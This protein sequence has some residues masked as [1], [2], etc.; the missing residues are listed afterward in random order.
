MELNVILPCA[1]A[2]KRLGLSYPKELYEI[3]P[4]IRLIDFS[5]NH[6]LAF[7][8]KN[9]SFKN[10]IELKIS[11]VIRPGKEEIIDY[12]RYRCP[13][14][15]IV[16]VLFNNDYFEWPGSVYSAQAVFEKKNLVLL[17]DSLLLVDN[18]C[19]YCNQQGKTLLEMVLS[20]LEQNNVCFGYI[21]CS[22]PIIL[23]Q[24]GA[25]RISH[26]KVELFCDKPHRMTSL[27]NSY[28]GCY[29]FLKSF[30]KELY[31][32]LI[33]SLLHKKTSICGCSFNSVGVFPLSGYYDLGTW[34]MISQFQN[35]AIQFAD[36]LYI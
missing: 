19:I 14:I 13:F 10:R 16:P 28:W 29:G 27:Y 21:A 31:N 3:L 32:F 4:G 20:A 9:C 12:I 11:V 35:D 36:H 33:D 7:Y 6:V 8:K 24:M 23:R 18:H 34:S 25:M 17:P 5:L 26:G 15:E 1:G 2:G 30:G 22:E